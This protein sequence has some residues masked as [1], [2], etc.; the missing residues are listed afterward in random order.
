[1]SPCDAAVSLHE[2]LCRELFAAKAAY[3]RR[4]LDQMC[5][6][7]A[8]CSHVLLE[9]RA[10]LKPQDGDPGVVALDQLYL[11]LFLGIMRVL[12]VKDPAQHLQGLIDLLWKLSQKMRVE[13]GSPWKERNGS[14]S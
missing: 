2:G 8:R 9:L 11:K 10:G 6:H 12:R 1:M 7:T 13:R 4:A 3:E 14:A 5:T